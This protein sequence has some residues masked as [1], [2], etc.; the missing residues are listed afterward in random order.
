MQLKTFLS[1]EMTEIWNTITTA[2]KKQNKVGWLKPPP[3]LTSGYNQ[4]K[5]P[6][7]I[8]PKVVHTGQLKTLVVDWYI[9]FGLW[10]SWMDLKIIVLLEIG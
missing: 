5:L 7:S 10:I 6:R 3:V 4:L 8:L 2:A 1:T 9:I